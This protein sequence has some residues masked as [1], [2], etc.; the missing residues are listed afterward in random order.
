MSG[1]EFCGICVGGPWHGEA[2]ESD[3]RALRMSVPQPKPLSAQ[4]TLTLRPRHGAYV[5]CHPNIW[6]WH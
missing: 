1:I 6:K 4:A 3:V 2:L 5:W